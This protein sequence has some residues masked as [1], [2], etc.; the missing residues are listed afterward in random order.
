MDLLKLTEQSEKNKQMCSLI[1]W[2]YNTCP[3]SIRPT[4]RT[5]VRPPLT[6]IVTPTLMGGW[7]PGLFAG[8]M[9]GQTDGQFPI[10]SVTNKDFIIICPFG[11]TQV[12]LLTKPTCQFEILGCL[13]F[14]VWP[15]IHP[16]LQ[17]SK[18]PSISGSVA[19][20]DAYNAG[21]SHSVT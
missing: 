2:E 12:G 1:N 14:T 18:A 19:F 7:I 17:K 8:L 4:N 3:T 13:D 20:K 11:F 15:H 9:G 5:T 16:L 10:N 21:G 6:F